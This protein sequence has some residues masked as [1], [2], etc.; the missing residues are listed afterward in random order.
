MPTK[1]IVMAGG[2]ATRL[3]PQTIAINKHVLPVNGQPM[4]HW[5]VKTLTDGG[6]EE[7]LIILNNSHGQQVMEF[8]EDG[9]QYGCS[10]TYGY[11]REPY[12]LM[13]HLQIGRSFARGEDVVLMLGDSLFLET[14]NFLN[15]PRGPHSWVTSLT[16]DHFE[17]YGQVEIRNGLIT[18]LEKVSC[19]GTGIVQTGVWVLPPD[20]YDLADHLF[21]KHSDREVQFT[22]LFQEYVREGRLTATLLPENSFLDLGTPDALRKGDQLLRRREKVQQEEMVF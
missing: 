3:Y 5:V 7:I 17:K 8:L 6:V 2:K 18:K 19:C 11:H 12:G 22:M 9:E 10:I 16:L 1:A 20:A 14:P 13:K 15:A 4:I 21:R